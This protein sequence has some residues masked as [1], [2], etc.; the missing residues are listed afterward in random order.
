M[1]VLVV[2]EETSTYL[3]KAR[4]EDAGPG[5]D[6][7]WVRGVDECCDRQLDCS[8]YREDRRVDSERDGYRDIEGGG[9]ACDNHVC[10]IFLNL[11][12]VCR[13]VKDQRLHV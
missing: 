11:K 10:A 3:G 5:E 8:V 4:I 2:S 6:R 9:D 13:V 7:D 12:P 1:C